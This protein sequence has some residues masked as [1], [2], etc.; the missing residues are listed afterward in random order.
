[1]DCFY[2]AVER[3]RDPRLI[4]KP[5]AVVQY[6]TSQRGMSD[7]PAEA[8]RWRSNSGP[9]ANSMGGIIAVSYEARARGVT[10]QMTGR[11]ARKHCPDVILV[12]VPTAFGKAD[13]RIYKA[14]GDE[15]VATLAKRADAT[16]KRSVDEVAIEITSEAERI[17][18]ERDWVTDLLPSVREST[19]LADSAVSRQ[20]ASISR[21]DT[22]RGH[23]GQ[24]NRDA[25]DAECIWE[26]LHDSGAVDPIVKRLVAG[27]IVVNEL[28]NEVKEK[29][30]FSCSGGVATNKVLA[31][32]GCGL[33]KPDQQTVLLPHAVPLL[34]R[35]LP[36]D[37]L[38]GLGGEFGAKIMRELEIGTAGELVDRGPDARRLFGEKGEWIV[39]LA[40]GRDSAADLVKDRQLVKSLSNGKTFFGK[41]KLKTASEVEYWLREFSGELHQRYKEQ[42][43]Q[44]QRAPTT[45]GIHMT[46]GACHR[47]QD[48]KGNAESFSKQQTISLGRHGTVSDIATA[49]TAC[50]HRW[51]SGSRSQSVDIVSLGLSLTKFVAVCS[52]APITSFFNKGP[53]E[54]VASEASTAAVATSMAPRL[55]P[56]AV[57]EA[58]SFV[59]TP[60]GV[61]FAKARLPQ[62]SFVSGGMAKSTAAA[63]KEMAGAVASAQNATPTA[64]GVGEA[65]AVGDSPP[66]RRRRLEAP[67]LELI[68]AAHVDETVLAELPPSIQRE[69]REQ[70]CLSRGASLLDRRIEPQNLEVRKDASPHRPKS[71]QDVIEIEID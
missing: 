4:G 49:A 29:L 14:A 47:W 34:L 45:I 2:V 7:L 40:S 5:C 43:E 37:R 52:N 48:V 51:L 21:D 25:L 24:Q 28:R 57:P 20:A 10:R 31:K 15:V 8:D 61:L 64:T 69:V 68:Q 65:I 18:S 13:L 46:V 17:L 16:E 54:A 19:H 56:S 42:L 30:G 60:L 41:S 12:Q 71:H 44:H 1:M 9:N 53:N 33:H 50:F 32:L 23:D 6:D 39:A 36:I 26:S 22:R 11:E 38:P 27:A 63:A 35:N 58:L 67:P 3:A 59:N 66:A 55:D 62:S 70:L